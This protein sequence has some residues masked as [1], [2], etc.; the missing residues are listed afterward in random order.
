MRRSKLL[1]KHSAKHSATNCVRFFVLGAGLVVG[2]ACTPKPSL[3]TPDASTA[4]A[5]DPQQ[6]ELEARLAYL[7]QRLEAARIDG[8]VPGMAIAIV[9]DD[10]LIY[11]HGFGVSDMDNNTPVTPETVFAIGSSTKAFTS[12]L[13][14]ML[15]DEGKMDWDDPVT[16]HLPDFQLQIDA[17]EDAEVVTIRDLLAH[18]T[19]F[20]RMGILWGANTIT[21]AQVLGYATKALPVAPFRAEFHYNNVTYMAAGEASAKAAG[22]SWEQLVASRLLEPLGMTHTTLDYAGAQADP[23]FSLGYTW[24]DDLDAFEPAPMRDLG[25]IAPAGSINSSV[26][27]MANWLRF[28]LANGE[29]EGQRLVSEATLTQTKTSQIELA[30]GSIDYGMGW[31]LREWQGHALVEHGGNIDGFAASVAMLPDDGLGMVLLTNVGMTPLQ[32]S[33]HALVWEALLTDAYLPQAA[34]SGE[35]FSRF[36]GKYPAD[37]PGFDGKPFEVVVK[38]GKLAV[39]VPGQTVYTLAAPDDD[40]WRVF[41]ATDEVAVSFDEDDEGQIIALRLHQGGMDLELLREGIELPPEVDAAQ[42]RAYLGHY[43]ADAGTVVEVKIHNGRLAVD[44]PGQMVFDLELPDTQ[45]DYHFRAKYDLFVSFVMGEGKQANEVVSMN[46]FESGKPTSFTREPGAKPTITLEQLHRKRK[47]DK[48]KRAMTKAALVHFEQRVDMINAGVTGTTQMW[49][50]PQ[51]RL[52][53]DTQFGPLGQALLVMY[54][55][56]GP[57]QS[58]ATTQAW[59]ESSFEP[60]TALEGLLLQQALLDHPRVMFG[61]W[62]D[63][64][65]SETVLRTESGEA[66]DVHVIELRTGELPSTR[67]HVDAK[68]GDVVEIHAQ[69]LS[70]GGLRIPT[71]VELSDYR[72]VAG[73]RLPFRIESSNPHTGTTVVTLETVHA[74]QGDEPG[75]FAPMPTD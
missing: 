42:V 48:R 53:Q 5:V 26:V 55:S 68:T 6:V 37:L 43:R 54:Q 69:V 65:E 35:D 27:D 17:A 62:R 56:E 52:R 11:A 72:K 61:D 32:T 58:P 75:R 71:T 47:T 7:E 60:R 13:V 40:E 49:F 45:G 64:Y 28:H 18:R 74:K 1:A 15:V 8:H 67:I 73:M 10:Q 51:G 25:A 31:M 21:R 16:R 4:V 24:R 29:F 50:D 14:G 3:E 12:T 44:I 30:P 70:A 39:D 22:V 36:V 9:K 20:A 46:L 63:F 59:S 19:G 23:A 33:A 66:G 34:G 38:D 41:E 2:F 57:A